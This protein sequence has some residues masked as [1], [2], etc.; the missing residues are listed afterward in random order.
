MIESIA[1]VNAL[2]R[3]ACK[4]G[5]DA[6][7]SDAKRL[8][9]ELSDNDDSEAHTE[10]VPLMVANEVLLDVQERLLESAA[11]C[12]TVCD[13]TEAKRTGAKIAVENQRAETPL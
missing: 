13:D 6:S 9:D 5:M 12:V 10:F 1:G 2:K 4:L 11:H 3:R 8:L 7:N